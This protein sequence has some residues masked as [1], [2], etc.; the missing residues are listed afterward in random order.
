MR[1]TYLTDED[2]REYRLA[3]G[4]AGGQHKVY[5]EDDEASLLRELE[6]LAISGGD[7]QTSAASWVSSMGASAADSSGAT[8]SRPSPSGQAGS[9]SSSPVLTSPLPSAAVTSDMS[10]R[11]RGF[12]LQ[13]QERLLRPILEGGPN[14]SPISFHKKGVQCPLI[15]QEI[16]IT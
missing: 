14:Y 4:G 2:G 6:E 12:Q 3:G 5:R 10:G 1:H 7:R 15:Q 16:L 9:D 8:L 13:A 11:Q